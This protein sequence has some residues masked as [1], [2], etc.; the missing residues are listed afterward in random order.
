HQ[1][2]VV[3]PVTYEDA[4]TVS[5]FLG[6]TADSGMVALRQSFRSVITDD[7]LKLLFPNPDRSIPYFAIIGSDSVFKGL[8]IP[9]QVNE[10]FIAQL[11]AGES[12]YIPTL[13]SLPY[14]PLLAFSEAYSGNRLN[15]PYYYSVLS[16]YIDGFTFPA[17]DLI[18]SARDVRR[19]Y[20]IN[21][22]LLRLYC[23]ALSSGRPTLPKR[24]IM[25]VDSAAEYE[26]HYRRNPKYEYRK[27]SYSHEATY[28]LDVPKSDV[29][30]RLLFELNTRTGVKGLLIKRLM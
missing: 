22:P 9:P 6:R 4:K 23:I 18:D 5:G 20:Y 28:P 12:T 10:Q 8:T 15:K 17:G 29:R 25:L 26:Y 7:V 27:H 13:Q 1:D 30:E 16:G 24:R 21:Y 2:M 3:L 14:E 19:Y 11:I